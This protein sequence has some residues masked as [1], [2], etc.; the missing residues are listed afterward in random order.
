MRA[1]LANDVDKRLAKL[2]EQSLTTGDCA[3]QRTAQIKVAIATNDLLAANGHFSTAKQIV[4]YDVTLTGHQ[5]ADCVQLRGRAAFPEG[6]TRGPGGGRGCAMS[7]LSGGLSN[8]DI[9]ERLEAMR[10]ST[11]LFCKGLSDLHAVKVMNLGVYP[12]KLEASHEIADV[13]FHVQRMLARPPLWLR[14]SLGLPIPQ[15]PAEEL[16]AA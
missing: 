4:F 8:A 7:D 13:I 10:G 14:R 3:M 12:V 2:A 5:F 15:A 16:E 1:S 9:D 6:Q 11:M